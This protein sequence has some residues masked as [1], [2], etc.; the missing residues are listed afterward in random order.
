M[1]FHM[2]LPLVNKDY[3]DSFSY[4]FIGIK[5]AQSTNLI[6]SNLYLRVSHLERDKTDTHFRYEADKTLFQCWYAEL[7]TVVNIL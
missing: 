4:D 1:Q 3:R 6:L 7:Y 5:I 2:S